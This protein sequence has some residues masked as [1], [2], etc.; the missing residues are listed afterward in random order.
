MANV[1]TNGNKQFQPLADVEY[2][3][4]LKGIQ[5]RSNKLMADVK[6]AC[7]NAVY[8]SIVAGRPQP[9]QR[10]LDAVPK[11]LKRDVQTFLTNAGKLQV[12]KNDVTKKPE[13][14]YLAK[15]ELP[16]QEDKA[17]AEAYV[18]GLTVEFK[19]N[20]VKRKARTNVNWHDVFAK[21]L[22]TAE[23]IVKALVE[24]RN[25]GNVDI[26]E[27]HAELL[28][29]MVHTF[30]EYEREVMHIEVPAEDELTPEEQRIAELEAEIVALKG[31]THEE[32]QPVKSSR[33]TIQ[34][35]A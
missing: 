19:R 31:Q 12:A 20:P 29:R 32:A 8:F 5:T 14:Q 21:D 24:Q 34:K 13:F 23:R 1:V 33:K 4:L 16:K 17:E 35:A 15:E 30:R 2:D 26:H 28:E 7:M 18:K 22:Q 11:Y 10:L 3:K 27:E 6:L 25:A 9:A